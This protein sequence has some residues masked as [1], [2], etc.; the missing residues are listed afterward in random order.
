MIE[1]T[2]RPLVK[3]PREQTPHNKRKPKPFGITIGKVYNLLRRELSRIN[4]E[5]PVAIEIAIKES[6]IKLDGLPYASCSRPNFPGV[7]LAFRTKKLGALQYACDSCVKWEDNLRAIVLTLERLRLID[8]YGATS[9]G[10]QY[11]GWKQLPAAT[12][13]NGMTLEEAA[14]FVGPGVQGAVLADIE[15]FKERYR[16][17]AKQH[18]HDA[19]GSTEN[20]NRLQTA[21]EL[22]EAHFQAR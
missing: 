1:F 12:T 6:D 16:H 21:K 10:E 3:W 9:R 17:A 20:W 2:F 15:V 19:G 11:A 4:A 13:L 18:H 14:A 22:I 7:I 5:S 8:L